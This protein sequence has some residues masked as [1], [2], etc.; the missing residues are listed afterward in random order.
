LP[1]A[2]LVPDEINHT[3]AIN[4]FSGQWQLALNLLSL[5]PELRER[6]KKENEEETINK[7]R[8]LSDLNRILSDG[9]ENL[10]ARSSR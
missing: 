10:E 2:R 8:T 5:M 9:K 6:R 3:A 1:D 7:H 4:A